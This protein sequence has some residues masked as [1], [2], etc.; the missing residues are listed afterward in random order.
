MA[1]LVHPGHPLMKA[2]IDLQL[3]AH[4][5]KLKQGAILIN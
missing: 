4:R 2:I 3:E 5:H 1:E